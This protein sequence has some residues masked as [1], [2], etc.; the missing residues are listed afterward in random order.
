MKDLRG[1]VRN[2]VFP[3]KLFIIYVLSL[4]FVTGMV[5]GPLNPGSPGPED[6]A[7][8]FA[9]M[10]T[11]SPALLIVIFLVVWNFRRMP[12]FT[13][14]AASFAIWLTWEIREAYWPGFDTDFPNYFRL[15]DFLDADLI[16]VV[17]FVLIYLVWR[18]W[19]RKQA[20]GLPVH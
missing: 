5:N 19:P 7:E 9:W 14:M 8:S 20:G 12:I 1:G 15:W 18:F 3:V 11:L 10:L 4:T 17:P 6:Y 16:F 13:T 2:S